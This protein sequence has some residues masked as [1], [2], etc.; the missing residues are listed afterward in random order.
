MLQIAKNMANLAKPVLL[1][2]LKE[3]KWEK[4]IWITVPLILPHSSN[5]RVKPKLV[6]GFFSDA[7]ATM[8]GSENRQNISCKNLRVNW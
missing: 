8:I 7:A 6:L 3:L 5:S 1:G 2:K 4:W